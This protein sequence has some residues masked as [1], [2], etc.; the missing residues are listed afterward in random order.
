MV[1]H[2]ES[3][4]SVPLAEHPDAYG[5]AGLSGV[6]ALGMRLRR[7]PALSHIHRHRPA[8][9]LDLGCGYRAD[10][11]TAVSAEVTRAVGVDL[12]VDATHAASHGI[13]AVAGEVVETLDTFDDETFDYVTMISV[14][15]HLPNPQTALNGI[16][17]VLAP[18]GTA[19]VHVPTWLGKPVLEVMAFRRGISTESIDDHR[20]YY[21]IAELWPMVIRAGFR[22]MNV[23]MRYTL[24]GFAL[25]ADLRKPAACA[26]S[27]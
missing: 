15:E 22:P 23:R 26:P 18:G 2:T 17:R 7:R 20:T 25:R 6:E 27:R 21:R 24:L 12:E 5:S 9:M 10:L 8:T 13:L 11:L 16:H 1:A 19:T 4:P 3:L 14:L